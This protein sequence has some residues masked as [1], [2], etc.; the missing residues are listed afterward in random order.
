MLLPMNTLVILVKK[1]RQATTFRFSRVC[2]GARFWNLLN[3][4]VYMTIG[5][6]IVSRKK[7]SLNQRQ[8]YANWN[9]FVYLEGQ[10]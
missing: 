10:T 2:S 4:L 6:E 1:T 5:F 8:V 3:S 7:T 9:N